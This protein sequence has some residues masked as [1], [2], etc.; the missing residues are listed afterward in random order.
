M[1]KCDI[2]NVLKLRF[3]FFSQSNILEN[4][5]CKGTLRIWVNSLSVQ[6][7]EYIMSLF[8]KDSIEINIS[9]VLCWY[10]FLTTIKWCWWCHF[11]L[12]EYINMGGLLD[13]RVVLETIFNNYD[14]DGKGNLSPIQM[15]ILHGDLRMGGISLPQASEIV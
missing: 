2:K 9:N 13:E 4:L 14:T 11:F 15:Q 7:R 8:Y 6:R 12:S 1:S 10:L 3:V 5:I